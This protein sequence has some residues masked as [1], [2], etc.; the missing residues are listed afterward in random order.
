MVQI[1]VC[2][3]VAKLTGYG[4]FSKKKKLCCKFFKIPIN[5]IPNSKILSHPRSKF[6]KRKVTVSKTIFEIRYKYQTPHK[7]LP[8]LP[9]GRIWNLGFQDLEFLNFKPPT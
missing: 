1:K 8:N 2:N 4:G 6:Q 7:S 9:K 3:S 5:K